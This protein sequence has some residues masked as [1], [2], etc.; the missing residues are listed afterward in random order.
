MLTNDILRSLRFILKNN[1]AD[2]VRLLAL[3]E[4]EVTAPQ[5]TAW[6]KKEEEEGFQRCPDIVLSSLLNGLIYDRRGRDESRPPLAAERRITN[7]TVLKKL[8]VAF[9][10]KTDD[11]LA[12][13]TEQQFKVSMPEITAMMRAADHKNFRECGDQFLRYFLRGLAAREHATKA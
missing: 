4:V 9:N 11:I 8:R 12:I 2:L 3:A 5:L 6:I 1:N 13:L 10:L 7:N